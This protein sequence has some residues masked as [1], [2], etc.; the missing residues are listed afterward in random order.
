MASITGSLQAM[1]KMTAVLDS[2]AAPLNKV[3]AVIGN[4]AKIADITIGAISS[5][6]KTM[7]ETGDKSS[8][9]SSALGKVSEIIGTVTG[10]MNDINA[11]VN[12][13]SKP[14]GDAAEPPGAAAAEPPPA[15]PVPAEAS[16][17][18]EPAGSSQLTIVLDKLTESLDKMTGAIASA[19]RAVDVTISRL[20]TMSR[21]MTKSVTTTSSWSVSLAKTVD[22][23]SRMAL[24]LSK[25]TSSTATVTRSMEQASAVM[26]SASESISGPLAGESGGAVKS[27]EA[28]SGSGKELQAVSDNL[29]AGRAQT[30]PVTDLVPGPAAAD[31]APGGEPG[32]EGGAEAGGGAAETMLQK[33]DALKTSFTNLGQLAQDNLLPVAQTLKDTFEGSQFQP[34]FDGMYSG[35]TSVIQ[36]LGMAAQAMEFVSAVIEVWTAAQE[37]LNVVMSMNPIALII[38]LVVALIAAFLAIIAALKPVREFFAAVFRE[39]GE[40]LAAAVGFYIDMWTGFINLFIE[41]LNTLLAGVGKVAG[42]LGKI[43][44]KD[45]KMDIEIPEVDSSKLKASVQGGIKG[46]FNSVANATEN[47]DITKH[48]FKPEK[49]TPPEP[50]AISKIPDRGTLLTPGISPPGPSGGKLPNID[51]VGSVGNIDSKVDVSSEDIKMMRDLAEMKSIQNYVTLTPTVNVTTGNITK[52]ADVDEVI[53]R[54]NDHMSGEIEASAQGAY[55]K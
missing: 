27:I 3:N 41:G 30:G 37:I 24:S 15:V 48:Q 17:E 10:S 44:G 51:R 1:N 12:N 19:S 16:A 2:V 28:A 9:M 49:I 34:F 7:G 20:S 32:A 50:P 18:G 5:I 14:A 21:T 42:F 54:I 36:Y 35:L 6:A 25:V 4:M 39:I 40:I 8:G 46:A 55:G 38:L 22:G 45:I 47:F 26:A 43:I 31:A 53:K 11:I 23:T 52:E 13:A 29:N 33:V